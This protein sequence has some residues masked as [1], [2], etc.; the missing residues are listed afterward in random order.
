MSHSYTQ[1]YWI[2]YSNYSST[3]L[4]ISWHKYFPLLLYQPQL[5]KQK[6]DMA[7]LVSPVLCLLTAHHTTD[8]NELIFFRECMLNNCDGK[9]RLRI[10]RSHNEVMLHSSLGRTAIKSTKTNNVHVTEKQTINTECCAL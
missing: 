5:V 7:I 4:I 1:A 8:G 6:P 3:T 10:A 9:V 2:N